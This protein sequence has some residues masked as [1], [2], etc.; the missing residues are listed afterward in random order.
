MT[1]LV[2]S[3]RTAIDGGSPMTPSIA[4]RVIQSFQP[5]APG[6]GILTKRETEILQYLADGK[7]YAAIG[8]NIYLSVDGVG[9][10][11]RN[12]Y[13]KLEV[14]NRGEAVREGLRRKLI[15]LLG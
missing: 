7:S 1:E 2:Q 5:A 14:K 15:K 9:Y 8:K 6:D 11:I 10:H 3:I 4:R 13:E 12:I